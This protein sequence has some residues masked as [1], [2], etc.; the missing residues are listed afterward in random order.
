M[1]QDWFASLGERR[2]LLVL[3]FRVL[4]LE[5]VVEGFEPCDVSLSS[6]RIS[7]FVDN[8]NRLLLVDDG[9]SLVSVWFK[10][11]AS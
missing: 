5:V 8:D 6:S 9:S 1:V 4:E 3:E 10:M 11:A 2:W 7:L